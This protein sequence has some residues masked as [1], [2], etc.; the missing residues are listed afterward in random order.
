[1]SGVA[2]ISRSTE[3][4][5]EVERPA[6]DRPSL[7]IPGFELLETINEGAMGTVYVARQLSVDRLVAIKVLSDSLA[8]NEEYVERFWREAK[9][10]AKLAH[11]NIV[12]T[13]DAG[14]VDGRPYLVME[15]I[16]G[17]RTVKDQLDAAGA[18]DEKTALTIA[19]AAAEALREA[20]RRGLVHRDVKP[21]NLIVSPNGSVK[22]LDL[23]LAR[24]I[25]DASWALAEA[26]MAVGT[27]EYIS[28]EQIRGQIDV[29]IRSDIYSLGVSLYLMVTGQL[30]FGGA[31]TDEA[32][33]RHVDPSIPLVPPDE[34]N[35]RLSTGVATVIRKMMAR[36]REDRYPDPASLIVDLERL[37]RGERPLLAEPEPGS[38]ATLAAGTPASNSHP[39]GDPGASNSAVVQ[40]AGAGPLVEVWAP[41]LLVPA[42]VLVVTLLGALLVVALSR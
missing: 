25:D 13:L 19:L 21:A 17:G 7:Q 2:P 22:L 39:S 40:P 6:A 33:R 10:A 8:H 15:K 12:A 18:F 38:L 32:L 16:D 34:V 42:L 5:T 29:D 23:G 4:S 28:P 26:G 20:E 14:E 24:L 1:M 37:L 11:P 27:P 9:I 30:P 31:T 35:P 41:L 36:S 3:L